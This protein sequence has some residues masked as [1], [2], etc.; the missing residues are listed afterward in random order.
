MALAPNL[1]PVSAL[2]GT[3]A[4]DGAGSY[5]TIALGIS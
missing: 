3:W 2:L 5:P 1:R 4:G